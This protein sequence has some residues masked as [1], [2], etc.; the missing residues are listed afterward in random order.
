M[1]F[2]FIGQQ[3]K[4]YRDRYE[5]SLDDFAEKSGVSRSMLCQLEMGKTTPTLTV[6]AKISTAMDMRLGDLVDPMDPK[7]NFF[8]TKLAKKP[9]VSM[10]G[11]NEWN[12]TKGHGSGT[13]DV[14]RWTS[15]KSIKKSVGLCKTRKRSC[16]FVI[17]GKCTILSG[18][19]GLE[20]SE[21]EFLDIRSPSFGFEY[22]I[23]P[24]SAGIWID[25][26]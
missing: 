23:S 11:Y 24:N 16:L 26:Y 9:D 6:A 15:Q 21:G 10:G 8:L 18:K 1:D 14:R 3:I 19:T 12:L 20:V 2:S 7:E 22:E 25:F 13:L 4:R 17:S 5:L